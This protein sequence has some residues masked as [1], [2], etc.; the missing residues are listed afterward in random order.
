MNAWYATLRRPPLTPPSWVFGPVWTVLYLMIAASLLLYYRA[1]GRA[2]P[3]RMHAL[4]GVHVASNLAWT[5]LFFGCQV[6]GAALVDILA[7]VG[8]LLV[9]ITRLW[10]THPVSALLLVPYLLWVSFAT[11]LNAGFYA[12]NR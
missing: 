12:L 3:A 1:E 7:L 6:P 5:P 4:I 10:K 8:T 9:L 2:V 11:Y